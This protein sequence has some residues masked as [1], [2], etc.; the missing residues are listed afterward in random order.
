MNAYEMKIYTYCIALIIQKRFKS[1]ALEKSY[2]LCQNEMKRGI[3]PLSMKML[4]MLVLSS[5]RY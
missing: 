3:E 2:D 1:I 5:H 4:S